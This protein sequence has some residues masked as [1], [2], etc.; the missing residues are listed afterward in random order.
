M[1]KREELLQKQQEIAEALRQEEEAER[2]LV[3]SESIE[4]ALETI[5]KALGFN[6]ITREEVADKIG[7]VTT[8]RGFANETEKRTFRIPY[9][10][11]YAVGTFDP[12]AKVCELKLEE[13][14]ID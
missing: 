14:E 1:T 7:L 4:K 3:T 8:R 9:Y 11:R 13:K 2:K 12:I 10:S 5:K 6:L